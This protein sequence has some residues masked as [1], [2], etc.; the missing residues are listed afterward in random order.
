MLDSCHCAQALWMKKH[1]KPGDRDAQLCDREPDEYFWTWPAGSLLSERDGALCKAR[2]AFLQRRLETHAG[3]SAA[4]AARVAAV[5]RMTGASNNFRMARAAESDGE[6]TARMSVAL[7]EL[8]VR[9]AREHPYNA[10]DAIDVLLVTHAQAVRAA[11]EKFAGAAWTD[12][13][14]CASVVVSATVEF[15]GVDARI[16]AWRFEASENIDSLV[17]PSKLAHVDDK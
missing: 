4:A 10:D 2:S 16:A 13:T 15:D 11:L 8:V 9:V 5:D 6:A 3:L 14:Y 1:Q 17:V 7:D 12:W